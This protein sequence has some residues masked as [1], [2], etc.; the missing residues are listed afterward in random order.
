MSLLSCLTKHIQG[1]KIGSSSSYWIKIYALQNILN[2]LL[3]NVFINERHVFVFFFS[4]K[5]KIRKCV[6]IVRTTLAFNVLA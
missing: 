4:A 6:L 1:I 3:L 2:P 5:C